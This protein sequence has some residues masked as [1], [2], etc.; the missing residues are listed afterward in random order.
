MIDN[1]DYGVKM[2]L[3]TPFTIVRSNEKFFIGIKNRRMSQE[4]DSEKD[5]IEKGLKLEWNNILELICVITEIIDEQKALDLP[6]RK[7]TNVGKNMKK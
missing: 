4:Y 2:V 3:N 6:V 7:S 5:A 1:E